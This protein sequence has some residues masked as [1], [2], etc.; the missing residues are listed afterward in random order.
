MKKH[1]LRALRSHY[2]VFN[3]SAIIDTNVYI[4]RAIRDSEFHNKSKELLNS[5]SKWITPTIVIHEVVWTLSELIGR[6]NTLLYIKSLLSHRKVE[7]IPVTKQ[8]LTWS[9]EKISEENLSLTRHNDKIIL[10]IAKRLKIP[11]LSFDKRLLS[12]ATKIGIAIISPYL[13]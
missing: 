9:I 2:V 12:Q 5:L 6:E 8:D 4:Y 7:I 3:L 10:S 1:C 11:I 13:S